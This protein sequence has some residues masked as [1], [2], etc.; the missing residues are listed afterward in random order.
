MDEKRIKEI[1]QG[2]FEKAKEGCASHSK[3]ALSNHISEH[4]ELSSKT[5]ERAYDRYINNKRD[6][7]IPQAES[8]DV[9]C[10]YLGFKNYA[11]YLKN[12]SFYSSNY[13]I[14]K[15]LAI[16]VIGVF[17][18]IVIVKLWPTEEEKNPEGI[19]SCMTWADSLYIPISCE[20]GPYSK[21][22]TLVVPMD[23]IKMKKFKKV[24]VNI[25]TDFFNED[26][27]PKIWY[28]KNKEGEIEYFTAPGLHPVTG[29]TL[30]EITEYIIDKYVPIHNI[31]AD[32]YLNNN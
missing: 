17:L 27:T 23:K 12:N 30:D 1:V 14:I 29:K 31:K 7:G 6:V 16:G 19:E 25:L 18:A 20:T 28:Y 8:I 24:E 10:Q 5:L 3:F 11:D 15:Y 9:L 2:V 13:K 21:K 22:G 4:T 32:S 26:G